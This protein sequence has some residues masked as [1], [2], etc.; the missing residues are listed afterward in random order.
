MPIN[1]YSKV[2]VLA[3]DDED[4]DDESIDSRASLAPSDEKCTE[5][6]VLKITECTVAESQNLHQP[7]CTVDMDVDLKRV[8]VCAPC[9]R[10]LVDARDHDKGSQFSDDSGSLLVHKLPTGEVSAISCRD[11]TL[12][13]AFVQVDGSNRGCNGIGTTNNDKHFFSG[14]SID[15]YSQLDLS[16][17]LTSVRNSGSS[18]DES[19][20]IDG[21]IVDDKTTGDFSEKDKAN[22]ITVDDKDIDVIVAHKTSDI[23]VESNAASGVNVLDKVACNVV[24]ED[25]ANDVISEESDN[26]DN[27]GDIIYCRG[28]VTGPNC[29]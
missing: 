8:G 18:A 9:Q 19:Y 23:S 17:V 12:M 24:V 1:S 10:P 14:H 22:D 16:K 20:N 11:A 29:A 2:Q 4:E 3:S 5:S 15:P 6:N 13:P 26:N 7:A 25:Q 21:F 27:A 28:V